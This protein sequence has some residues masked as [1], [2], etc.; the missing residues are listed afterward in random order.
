[1]PAPLTFAQ[2]LGRSTE[3]DAPLTFP[4]RVMLGLQE[5]LSLRMPLP[6]ARRRIQR[7]LKGSPHLVRL[8]FRTASAPAE[9]MT[10]CCRA[11]TRMLST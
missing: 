10:E 6:V 11:S 9:L 5:T 2:E 7:A 4:N 1:M 8:S 3:A